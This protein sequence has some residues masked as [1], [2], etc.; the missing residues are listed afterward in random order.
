M[1]M[2]KVHCCLDRSMTQRPMKLDEYATYLAAYTK[3]IEQRDAIVGQAKMVQN[4]YDIL[5]E[6][7]GKVPPH[8][9]VTIL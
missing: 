3:V 2:A 9:Q 5:V 4:L 8:D 6:Y 1:L 7:G